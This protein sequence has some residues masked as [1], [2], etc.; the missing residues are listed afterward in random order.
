MKFKKIFI[1]IKMSINL[2]LD[3]HPNHNYQIPGK[4]RFP[5]DSLYC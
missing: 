1:I 3:A 5:S 4:T 2:I